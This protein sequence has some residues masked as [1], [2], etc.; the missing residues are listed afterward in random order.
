[1]SSK[2]NSKVESEY[3]FI[4]INQYQIGNQI[5]NVVEI[6]KQ[7]HGNAITTWNGYKQDS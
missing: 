1:M 4:I 6:M 2:L 3:G 5:Q 7:N